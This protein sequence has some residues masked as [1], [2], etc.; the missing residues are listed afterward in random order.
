MQDLAEKY[1]LPGELVAFI[2]RGFLELLRE[3]F[4]KKTVEFHI[5]SKRAVDRHGRITAISLTWIHPAFN[6]EFCHFYDQSPGDLPNFYVTE[7]TTD[8]GSEIIDDLNS[9][10]DLA[11]WLVDLSNAEFGERLERALPQP[12]QLANEFCRVLHQWLEPAM[13]A[14]I[15]RRNATPD[16]TRLCASHD[17]C[18]SN[19]AM[20]AAQRVLGIELDPRFNEDVELMSAAWGIA[21]RR[22]FA[23]LDSG[24]ANEG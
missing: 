2:D 23:L 21:R 19:Q 20:I 8:V 7:D 13:I 4:E 14:E 16:Y 12:D 18:D 5:P 24:A 11:D 15:N 10:V 1:G 3:D 9:A 22:G 17:F 6:A